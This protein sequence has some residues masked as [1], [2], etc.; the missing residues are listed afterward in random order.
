MGEDNQLKFN[1]AEID[2]ENGL[3]NFEVPPIR[4]PNGFLYIDHYKTPYRY[5]HPAFLAEKL[6]E[7]LG[8]DNF[9][10]ENKKLNP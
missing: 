7:T 8:Y 5:K 10:F 2:H 1:R 4:Q 3:L 6:F 9:S